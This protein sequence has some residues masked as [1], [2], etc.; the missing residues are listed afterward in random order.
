MIRE[1][2]HA[3]DSEQAQ[4]CP[5]SSL[6][7]SVRESPIIFLTLIGG[8]V[9]AIS[10]WGILTGLLIG[11]A[12]VG[13]YFLATLQRNRRIELL[14][15]EWCETRA[16]LEQEIGERVQAELR[17][18]AYARS[19]EEGRSA[20]E[21]SRGEAESASRAK[22]EFLANMSHE[23]RTPINGIV[24]M[25]GLMGDTS[26]DE[27][28]ADFV[29]TIET[30]AEALLSVLDDVLDL[31]RFDAGQVE[32]DVSEFDLRGCLAAV[33][34]VSYPSAAEK[35]IE[36]AWVC[37]QDIP[38]LMHGDVARLRQVLI[39]L[40]GNAVKFTH[41]GE[42]VLRAEL[43]GCE[44]GWAHLCIAVE[45]TGI[46]IEADALP[47]LFS[48]FTQLDAST[49]R[50]FG[51]TGLGLA[52]CKQLVEMMGGEIGVE[53]TAL[54][55]S[56]FWFRI[57]LRVAEESPAPVDESLVPRAG[58]RLLVVDDCAAVREH[59]QLWSEGLG[60]RC[61]G[62]SSADEALSLARSSA[63][64]GEPFDALLL[65]AQQDDG[66]V[67]LAGRLRLDPDT[68]G[69]AL[70]LLSVHGSPCDPG[71]LREHGL[72]GWIT[73]PLDDL[74][75]RRAMCQVDRLR[76]L[77]EGVPGARRE[78]PSESAAVDGARPTTLPAIPECAPEA[79]VL[80]VL[81]AEDNLVNQRV[82]VLSLRKLGCRVTTS[83]NGV[84]AVEAL[85]RQEFDLVLMDCQMPLMSGYDA[86]RK[87]RAAEER[88]SRPRLPIIALTANAMKG[89]RD[90]CLDSG[91]DDYLA[92]PVRKDELREVLERW[93][94]P[95]RTT[96]RARYLEK[97]SMMQSGS[98]PPLDMD[99]IEG[100]KDLGGEDDP[101]LFGELVDLFLQDTPPRLEAIA[102]AIA[103]RN[104]KAIEETAHALKSSCGN[105]GAMELADLCRKIE[106]GGREESLD[107]V[108]QL[109]DCA[110]C[111]FERVS[112]A[113]LGLV[114]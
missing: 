14:T 61:E 98:P 51:G 79:D 60:L 26:L 97:D 15:E 21:I 10:T 13:A 56:R 50:A 113:L 107:A 73:K 99:V 3:E 27:D 54:Q 58:S 100:L 78:L 4:G 95:R 16:E 87:I 112:D 101:G 7:G 80:E 29:R 68:A 34:E 82:A 105:L 63:Q 22:S 28:Q 110:R 17:L 31:A 65:D 39:N 72:D 102:E 32:L 69:C 53:S 20:L 76:E 62:A 83:I 75:L 9:L 45:D 94:R 103:S 64:R 91:M 43:E 40:L 19:L 8:L 44:R 38:Q 1:T 35:G 88:E 24:G 86:T 41:E 104:G 36:L 59:V 66:G 5:D 18:R 6:E 55:G 89:D 67:E 109:I 11:V 74:R 92:K 49:T 37:Q 70:V 90:K 108:E 42:V 77:S 52:L 33:S 57:A 84:Q 47:L 46:G 23:I 93:G 85:G 114:V 12:L 2:Q 30:S 71:R 81:L 96:R 111:E 106:T 25:A 48:P